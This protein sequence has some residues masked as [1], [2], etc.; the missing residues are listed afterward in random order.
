MCCVQQWPMGRQ[1]NKII[2]ILLLVLLHVYL[3]L[4]NCCFNLI[5]CSLITKMIKTRMKKGKIINNS[6]V[7]LSV[8]YR[9]ETLIMVIYAFRYHMINK[10]LVPGTISNHN[11]AVSNKYFTSC[12]YLPTG[13]L[14]F[15]T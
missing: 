8:S 2:F 4:L 11:P 15:F 9:I 1:Q 3:E 5:S 10:M 14:L 6:H 13:H 12:V 7:V